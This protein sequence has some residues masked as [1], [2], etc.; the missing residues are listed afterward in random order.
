[1]GWWRVPGGPD[2][3]SGDQPADVMCIA[4]DQIAAHSPRPSMDELL[5]ALETALR[6][7][8]DGAISDPLSDRRIEV[9]NWPARHR[10]TP[11]LE[12][13][14]ILA[15]AIAEISSI[16]RDS[17]GRP[18][19]VVEILD[20]LAFVLRP[21]LGEFVRDAPGDLSDFRIDA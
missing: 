2:F 1:M 7:V 15:R 16:Y 4:V 3:L 9:A 5:D 20:A 19:F 8:P 17:I 12:R 6:G 14:Q 11:D 10:G 21:S 18:P 13:T